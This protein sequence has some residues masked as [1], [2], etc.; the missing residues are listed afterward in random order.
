M[1]FVESIKS[2]F[3]KAFDVKGRAV[4]SEY[5]YFVLFNLLASSIAGT[6]SKS[7]GDVT[8]IIL[9]IPS[10][11]VAIRRMH[12]VDKSGW[13]LL[14]P[15]YNLYLAVKPGTVGPN[16]FDGQS[17]NPTLINDFE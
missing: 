1:N 10:I 9:L 4:R 8:D 5:W 3:N 17:G 11:T 6:I 12:D 7:L 13:F 14:V 16:R 15:F 2:G